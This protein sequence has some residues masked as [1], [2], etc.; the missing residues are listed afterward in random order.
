[1]ATF[2]LEELN[3][4]SFR[5]VVF[6]TETTGLGSGKRTTEHDFINGGNIT[7]ENGLKNKTFTI[8]GY[9][10]GDNYLA[11]KEKLIEAFDIPG[12][13][14]LVDKFYGTK[15]VIVDTY[16]V[17]ES[18]KR[19]GYA[20]LSITFKLEENKAIIEKDIVFTVDVRDES[21]ANFEDEFSNEIGESLL[22]ETANSIA[23]MW[24]K[25][26]D[27][28]KFLE[29]TRDTI[30][31]I[32]SKIGKTIS[33]I[34]IAIL[35]VESLTTEILS[36]LTSFDAVLDTDLY[37]AKEQKN[38][39][40]TLKSML[41]DRPAPSQ[42]HAVN[43]ANKQSREYTNTV[44]AN[45]TQ[46]SIQ[47]LENIEFDTGGDLGDVKEDILVILDLLEEDL[48]IDN[49]TKIESIIIKQNLL[50]KY[51]KM[52]SEF[53]KFYTQ[54]YSGLQILKDRDVSITTDAMSLTMELYNDID[55]IEEVLQNNNIVDPIFI[56]GNLQLLDM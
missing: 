43:L 54:K 38:F 31:N 18:I 15:E 20:D 36:I 1:M 45:L 53:I 33:T 24:G 34:K 22:D 9:I 11:H 12:A 32:K 26:E 44:V 16:T 4:S 23:E 30:Q 3:K 14:T 28:I 19:F 46:I 56:N 35:S 48:I 52:R 41:E 55:R 51:H 10:G 13:G 27:T 50:N 37:G 8:K 49:T 6:Y 17:S 47:N 5:G 7:E 40:N 42:N 2:N 21:I 39:T 25:V 29:D